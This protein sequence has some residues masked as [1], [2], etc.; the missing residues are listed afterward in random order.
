LTG[1]APEAGTTTDKIAAALA[2][3]VGSRKNFPDASS[4]MPYVDL[5]KGT[6]EIM[7]TIE[8]VKIRVCSLHFPGAAAIAE[9]D[10]IKA[11]QALLKSDYSR[12]DASGLLTS[13]SFRSTGISV[14]CVRSFSS[15]PPISK[16]LPA[17]ARAEWRSRFPSTKA[18]SICGAR[19]EWSGN[20]V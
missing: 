18:W 12:K 7:F 6:Q 1:T 11:S 13:R 20:Q 3:S 19:P 17:H 16:N 10:L 9:A 5:A 15:R 2:A 14:V 8:G 4:H